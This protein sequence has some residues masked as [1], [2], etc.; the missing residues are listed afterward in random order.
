MA[1]RGSERVFA[2]LLL[3]GGTRG[4]G[5]DELVEALTGGGET[6]QKGRGIGQ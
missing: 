2:D 4:K 1:P 3:T 6:L 5:C